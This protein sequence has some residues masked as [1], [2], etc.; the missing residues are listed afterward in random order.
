MATILNRHERHQCALT[1]VNI[2]ISIN[3]FLIRA[4]KKK[5]QINNN[6]HCLLTLVNK[7]FVS[8]SIYIEIIHLKCNFIRQI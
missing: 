5:V 4:H 2:F 3:V 8:I 1:L 7:T 6:I